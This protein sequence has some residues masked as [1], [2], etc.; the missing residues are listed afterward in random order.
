LKHNYPK[1]RLVLAGKKEYYFKQL[2]KNIT[3]SSVREDIFLPGFVDDAELKW[4]YE[5]AEMYV[6]PSL[7]EGF[8]LPGLEAMVHGAPVA[9]SNATCLPEVYQDGAL[10]FD[11][12]DTDDMAAKIALLLDNP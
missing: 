10:Y 8:G 4:L 6:L 1:L 2:Q 3:D 11:P 7:S 12:L 9:S 5:N